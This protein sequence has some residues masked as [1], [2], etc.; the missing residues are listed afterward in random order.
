MVDRYNY[1]AL[2]ELTIASINYSPYNLFSSVA[3][4][5]CSAETLT[6]GEATALAKR[7]FASQNVTL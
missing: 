3:R 5:K 4:H 2:L 6:S 7:N 1:S